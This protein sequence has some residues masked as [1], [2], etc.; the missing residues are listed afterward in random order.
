MP[1][2]GHSAVPV[3]SQD[4]KYIQF[5]YVPSIKNTL[6]VPTFVVTL[7]GNIFKC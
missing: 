4:K 6:S 2:F 5:N 1:S 7:S 3:N